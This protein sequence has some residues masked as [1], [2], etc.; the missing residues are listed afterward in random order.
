MT[1]AGWFLP[2]TWGAV[3]EFVVNVPTVELVAAGWAVAAAV[4]APLLEV[5]SPTEPAPAGAAAAREQ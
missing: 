2:L 4:L 1:V 5:T 3:L